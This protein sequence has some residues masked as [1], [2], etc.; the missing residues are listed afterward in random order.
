MLLPKEENNSDMDLNNILS[1]IP[2]GLK[3]PLLKE[4]QKIILMC[5][6]VLRF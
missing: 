5:L 2:V 4:F 1:S 3:E 6:E